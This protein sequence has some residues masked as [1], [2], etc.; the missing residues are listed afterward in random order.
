MF[1]EYFYF[2]SSVF[3]FCYCSVAPYTLGIMDF[4]HIPDDFNDVPLT[5]DDLDLEIGGAEF[6][7]TCAKTSITVGV[8]ETVGTSSGASHPS[9]F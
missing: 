9:D 1:L 7:Q 4:P 2:S 6:T 8:T 5:I 3:L